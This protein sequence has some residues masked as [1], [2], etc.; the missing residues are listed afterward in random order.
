[1]VNSFSLWMKIC[2]FSLDSSLRLNAKE[3]PL[4]LAPLKFKFNFQRS[5]WRSQDYSEL[6]ASFW[7]ENRKKVRWRLFIEEFRSKWE[8]E[9]VCL[10]QNTPKFNVFPLKH[11][12]KTLQLKFNSLKPGRRHWGLRFETESKPFKRNLSQKEAPNGLKGA[13]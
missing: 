10:L 11:S 2:W 8:I 3:Y 13:D 5:K 7:K 4:F 9:T 12:Q 6:A 1:M